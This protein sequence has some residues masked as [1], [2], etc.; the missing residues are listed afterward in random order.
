ML[1]VNKNCLQIRLNTSRIKIYLS[2]CLNV[3]L[4]GIHYIQHIPC[5]HTYCKLSVT[6]FELLVLM[7][8]KN[9]LNIYFQIID[10]FFNSSLEASSLL[11]DSVIFTDRY[12]SQSCTN[13]CILTLFIIIIFTITTVKQ[14]RIK[15]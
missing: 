12:F 9:F 11:L 14:S 13:V 8:S 2:V 10:C 4:S 6:I 15:K 3:I 5:I 7:E 1:N